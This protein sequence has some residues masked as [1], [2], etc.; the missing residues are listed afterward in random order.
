VTPLRR[1][2]A[3]A[4]ATELLLARATGGALPW[5]DALVACA[6]WW[7]VDRLDRPWLTSA[8]LWAVLTTLLVP[9]AAAFGWPIGVAAAA[10]ALAA[11]RRPSPLAVAGT[12][13]TAVALGAPGGWA[14]L[15]CVGAVAAPVPLAALLAVLPGP[16]AWSSDDARP[17]VIVVTV[18]ALRADTAAGLRSFQPPGVAWAPAPWTLPSL[19]ALWTAQPPA[20]HGA[21]RAGGG[22]RTTDLPTTAELARAVGYQ[23]VALSGGNPF[24][25]RSFG[26]MR[27]FDEVGHPWQPTNAPLPRGRSPHARPRPLAARLLPSPASPTDADALVDAAL[28]RLA[29][30]DRPRLLWLHLMDLHLPLPAPPCGAGTLDQP[31]AR[32]LILADPWWSTPEGAACWRRSYEAAA[33][34]VDAALQRLLAGVDPAR[35][36]IVLT[37]DHGEALGDAGLEHGHSV[38]PPVSQVPLTVRA[39]APWPAPTS[40]VDLVDVGTTLRAVLGVAPG[41]GRDL[42]GPIAPRPIALGPALYGDATG[43]VDGGCLRLAPSGEA[44]PVD[45]GGCDIPPP[46]PV[47]RSLT[48]RR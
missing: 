14:L 30:R 29:E 34:R 21:G 45:P 2:L 46:A 32:H 47:D 25:G 41:G 11:T 35:S 15:A 7:I 40:A 13:T 10:V 48:P 5:P 44:I 12:A 17:D 24:T 6:A 43:V 36:V 4:A 19:A 1:A 37:A 27:G 8:A 16:P 39:A 31:G 18:D 9:P 20:V 33:E 28:R 23:T 26:L 3:S 38:R 42:R 22:F